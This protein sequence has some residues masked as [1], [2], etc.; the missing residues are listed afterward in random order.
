MVIFKFL[1]YGHFP[2][3]TNIM[4]IFKLFKNLQLY[5]VVLQRQCI[6]LPNMI[7]KYISISSEGNFLTFVQAV[8]LYIEFGRCIAAKIRYSVLMNT[9]C[10]TTH[11]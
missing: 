5:T 1:N 4:V 6:K 10:P 11:W 7:M 3:F 2:T 9:K 8:L